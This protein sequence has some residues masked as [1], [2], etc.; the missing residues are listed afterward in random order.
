M[1]NKEKNISTIIKN[2][3]Y[4]CNGVVQDII[5]QMELQARTQNANQREEDLTMKYVKG[6]TEE[7]DAILLNNTLSFLQSIFLSDRLQYFMVVNRK[8][9]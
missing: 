9:H 1:M 7:G 4:S 6:F 2:I 5:S 8:K 3:K